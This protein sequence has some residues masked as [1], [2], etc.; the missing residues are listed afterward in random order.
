MNKKQLWK[1]LDEFLFEEDEVI[2]KVRRLKQYD[3]DGCEEGGSVEHW[4]S[5]LRYKCMES[6]M[7]KCGD[8]LKHLFNKG[9][10][11]FAP[12]NED[13]RKRYE[14][15][16]FR[17]MGETLDHDCGAEVEIKRWDSYAEI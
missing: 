4:N 7:R 12:C 9:A 13:E 5:I 11:T 15:E 17:I 8:V 3:I 10:L 6:Y 1:L 16:F 14:D 2:E